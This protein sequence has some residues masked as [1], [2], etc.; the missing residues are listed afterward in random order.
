MNYFTTYKHFL[1]QYFTLFLAVFLTLLLPALVTTF[2][3]YILGTISLEGIDISSQLAWVNVLFEVIQEGML[4]PLF[5]IYGRSLSNKSDLINK[6]KTTLILSIV[7]LLFASLMLMIFIVPLLEIMDQKPALIQASSEYIRLELLAIPLS[8]AFK[9]ILVFLVLL[10]KTKEVLLLLLFQTGLTILGDATLV[11]DS[12]LSMGLGVNGIALSNLG[13]SVLVLFISLWKLKTI[14][15]NLL[16]KERPSFL[17]ISEW[18]RIGKY[19]SFESL[20]RNAVFILAILKMVNRV[21]EQAA[22]WIANGFIWSWLLLP[23]LAT[24]EIIKRNVG[25]DNKK[26]LSEVKHYLFS[27]LL[28]CVL[29]FVSAPYWKDFIRIVLNVTAFEAVLSLTLK[30]AVFYVIFSFNSVFDNI[31]YGLGRTDLM[32]YQS[33]VVNISVYGL[34]FLLYSIDAFDLNIDAI[35]NLFGTGI[36]VDA[37]ITIGIYLYLKKKGRLAFARS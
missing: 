16:K 13:A 27:I 23:V 36:T 26:S 10:K 17:W 5:F 22:F 1:K 24:G 19:S 34:A 30:L 2:R 21:E 15:F 28:I 33:I 3:I 37:F 20:I 7:I 31:L 11:N 25:E 4:L 6:F 8:T 9:L 32:L 18:W 12:S 29:W 35:I 14:G